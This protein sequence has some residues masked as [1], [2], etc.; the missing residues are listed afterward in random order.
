MVARILNWSQGL[1]C[2]SFGG[3][4]MDKPVCKLSGVDGNVFAVIGIVVRVLERAKQV[5]KAKE[6]KKRAWESGSYDDV[7]ALCFDYVDVE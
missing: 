6:F 7:L 3:G 5:E 1:Y 2:K 4:I